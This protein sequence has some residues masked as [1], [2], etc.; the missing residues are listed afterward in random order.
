MKASPS[1]VA[2]LPARMAH[3]LCQ[4]ARQD[5][6][7]TFPERSGR[8]IQRTEAPVGRRPRTRRHSGRGGGDGDEIAGMLDLGKS[9][10][11]DAN[12]G[13]SKDPLSA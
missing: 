3:E 10:K 7:N 11:R 6:W 13:A 5:P 8:Y 1:D 4:S 2:T 9:S 12:L